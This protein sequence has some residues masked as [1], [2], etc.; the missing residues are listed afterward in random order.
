[1]TEEG[2]DIQWIPYSEYDEYREQSPDDIGY[3]EASEYQET[4]FGPLPYSDNTSTRAYRLQ[5]REGYS[6][7]EGDKPRFAGALAS[8]LNVTQKQLDDIYEIMSELDL[9]VFGSQRRIETVA[10]GVITVVVNYDRFQR[11]RNPDATR[12]AESDEFKQLLIKLD[13]DYSDLGTAK[14]IVKQE[15]KDKGYF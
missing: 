9:A 1:M 7:T 5:R 10:L 12:I 11:R 8:D 14:R 4:E 13:I 2:D 3:A 6:P 15:L